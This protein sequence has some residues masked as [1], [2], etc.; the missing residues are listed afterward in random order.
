MAKWVD[1]SVVPVVELGGAV[2]VW[3]CVRNRNGELIA[4]DAYFVNHPLPFEGEDGEFPD[5]ASLNCDGE[6]AD[7]VGFAELLSHPD[8][9]GYCEP[10][11]GVSHWAEVEYPVPPAN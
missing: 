5:W 7:F 11:C 10:L 2:H 9:D 3:V 8:Y 4:R 6:P 1:A